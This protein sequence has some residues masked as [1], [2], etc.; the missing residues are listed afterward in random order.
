MAHVNYVCE[1][2]GKFYH[3]HYNKC[4]QCGSQLKVRCAGCHHKLEE[5]IC[6]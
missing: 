2:C 4:P 6:N 5:C 3:K 1:K